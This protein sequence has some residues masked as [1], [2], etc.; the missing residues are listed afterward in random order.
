MC[1]KIA[2]PREPS[3]I[4]VKHGGGLAVSIR[5][6]A[7]LVGAYHDGEYFPCGDIVFNRQEIFN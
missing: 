2:I 6:D 7:A 3:P 4:L 1:G 5:L